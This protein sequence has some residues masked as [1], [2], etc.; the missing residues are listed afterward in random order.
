M[1]PARPPSVLVLG[2]SGAIGTAISARFESAGHE[3]VRAGTA[4]FD[5]TDQGS[6][7]AWFR[8]ERPSV[9]VLVHSAGRNFP[10]PFA[11]LTDAEIRTCLEA[12]LIGFLAVV[13]HLLDELIE[14]RGRIVVV[15]SIFG[16]LSRRGRLAYATSKHALIGAMKSLALDLAADGVLVNAVSPGYMATRLTSQNNDPATIER[17]EASIPL[18]HLGTVFDV[19]DAVY[20]LSSSENRYITGQDLV[21]DGGLSIDGGRT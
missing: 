13:R 7:D 5:L 10:A 8:S 14:E 16:F 2:A 3:V 4:Q 11:E 12:N 9:G 19:A 17:L 18:G 21:V 20:F 6:I 1:T 15:S